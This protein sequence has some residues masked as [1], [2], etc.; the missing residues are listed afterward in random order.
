MDKDE[1]IAIHQEYLE[2]FKKMTNVELLREHSRLLANNGW[3]G[4]KIVCLSA[5]QVELKKRNIEIDN[6]SRPN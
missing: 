6:N 3:I 4:R 5:L 1:Q 2:Y